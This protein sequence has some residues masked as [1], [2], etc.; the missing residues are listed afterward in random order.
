MRKLVY[1]LPIFTLAAC[2]GAGPQSVG[3]NA[4]PGGGSAGGSG[5]TGGTG[6]PTDIYSQFANP[7]D[8]KTYSGVGG[9][10]VYDYSTDDRKCCNQ[11]GQTFA[12]TASTVRN[13]NI[14]LT[15]DP[16][17]ATFTL[18]V[19]DTASGA[20][21]DT[22]FQD[23]AS[24]TAF[25]GAKEPQWGVPNLNGLSGAA[26]TYNNP[27]VQYLQAGDG[28]PRSP[29][30]WS[31]S[32]F[33]NPGT[34]ATPPDGANG[35]RYVST[36]LFYEKP[37]SNTKYVSFA[38]YVRNSISFADITQDNL[39]IRQNTWHIEHG[40]FAYGA[41][42]SN[43]AVPTTGTGTYAGSMLGTMVYN[44][45]IDG[46]AGAVLPSYFQW[47]TGTSN[48]TVDF[49]AKTVGLSVAGVVLDPAIDRYTA[50][51]GVALGAA[52]RY[53][54]PNPTTFLPAG[55]TFAGSGT[56]TIDLVNKGGFAG[57][58]A[59]GSFAFTAP[60]GGAFANGTTSASVNVAGSSIDGAFFG[61]KAEEIGGG[62]RVVGGVA[63]QRIDII[64]AFTG[65]K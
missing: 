62:F 16:R 37:G 27:N 23:P 34:N 15:Y 13:S 48:L 24:R 63:D 8:A 61:P 14:S 42:T 54:G 38:G 39:T 31:G 46:Q 6:T 7:V 40:A 25:G 29:Y 12:G 57:S 47:L 28:D 49:A 17:D 4:V 45:T 2:G 9:V 33:V 60:S 43:N 35:A 53:T 64:G 18:M 59:G 19:K 55:T 26:A 65:K 41:V 22:R 44:P 11:Q 1:L 20:Q 58:F 21:T 51:G 5:G 32:G 52:D 3:S 56:A 36:T 30:S 50:P 10:Q